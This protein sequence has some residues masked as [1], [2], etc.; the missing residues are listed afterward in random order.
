MRIPQLKTTLN[1]HFS[2]SKIC[3]I[4]ALL[5]FLL[6]IFRKSFCYHTASYHIKHIPHSFKM[7]QKNFQFIA[8][9]QTEKRRKHTPKLL[10]VSGTHKDYLQY[11]CARQY[12]VFETHKNM[13]RKLFWCCNVFLE[14]NSLF[15]HLYN[16]FCFAR[17]T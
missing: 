8:N 10:F 4:H 15:V 11:Y 2:R 6:Y 12:A 3:Y 7:K 5:H 16:D 14:S 17:Y 1:F 13:T 9:K